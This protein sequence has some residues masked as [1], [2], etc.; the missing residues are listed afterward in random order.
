MPGLAIKRVLSNILDNGLKFTPGGGT[1]RIDAMQ[2][3]ASSILLFVADTGIGITGVGL[4]FCR[5]LVSAHGGEIWAE[6]TLGKGTT[7]FI[8]LPID[9]SKRSS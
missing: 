5:K 2:D 9:A 6:S 3:S 1:V 4:Y 8:R 7:I